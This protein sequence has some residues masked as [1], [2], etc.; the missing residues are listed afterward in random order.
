[1]SLEL[2]KIDELFIKDLLEAEPV[3]P[4]LLSMFYPQLLAK[5]K[6]TGFP[7]RKV[8][9]YRYVPLSPFYKIPW[10]HP[11]SPDLEA[12]KKRVL[13]RIHPESAR[14]YLVCINGVFEPALSDVSSLPPSVVVQPFAEASRTY[15]FYMQSRL[16]KK[17]QEESD[18]FA[19]L[20]LH[21]ARGGIF[22]YV[23]A[24]VV[25]D[26][27]LQVIH[28]TTGESTAAM[29][30]LLGFVGE[31][32]RL[33]MTTSIDAEGS[34]SWLNGWS[35]LH[36]DADADV[37]LHQ[38][39]IV[40]SDC[41]AFDKLTCELK[42]GAQLKVTSFSTGSKTVRQDYDIALTQPNGSVELKGLWIGGESRQTHV[43][44]HIRHQAEDCHSN[45]HFKGAL[46][47]SARSSFEGKIDVDAVAQGTEAY[48]L[49]NNL[50]LSEDAAA[51]A[52]PNLE[53]RAD[54]VSASHGVTM[55][56]LLEE[57]L[58]YFAARG[59]SELAAK[60]H[61]VRGFCHEMIDQIAQPSCR[62]RA[63]EKMRHIL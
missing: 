47:G 55:A 15:G 41:Y 46:L 37:F 63:L 61:L 29:P 48:Q 59:I 19:L 10:Q 23:P 9:T 57:E 35:D 62:Q 27:P 17:L 45:Q 13:P 32:S 28:V 14:S 12:L 21:L 24:G 3:R 36:L 34:S 33:Q 58:F 49:N 44:A 51:F 43:N 38:E 4:A 56:K 16:V 31:K 53:I 30:Q 22:L 11:K 26:S 52:K 7:N 1:M 20:C 6:Q 39:Y 25:I 18:P 5:L 42:K 40:P 60:K 50:I 54:A 8:E 2:K